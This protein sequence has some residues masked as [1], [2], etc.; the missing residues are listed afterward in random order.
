MCAKTTAQDKT[1]TE[2]V[3]ADPYWQLAFA[4]TPPNTP[5]HPRQGQHSPAQHSKIVTTL[6]IVIVIAE[7]STLVIIVVSTLVIVVVSTLLVVVRAQVA[8]IT[9]VSSQSRT[10]ADLEQNSNK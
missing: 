10:P 3:C 6:V 8:V 7:V 1:W 5:P 4:L 9:L 2:A